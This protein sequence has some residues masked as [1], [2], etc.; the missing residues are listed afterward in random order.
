[1]LGPSG[2]VLPRV[3]PTNTG[4]K[5]SFVTTIACWVMTLKSVNSVSAGIGAAC[6]PTL[7]A[8]AH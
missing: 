7:T 4:P 6:A 1:M 5:T 3:P 2:V 8:K